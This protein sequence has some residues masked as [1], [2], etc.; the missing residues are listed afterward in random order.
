MPKQR[1][2]S[3]HRGSHTLWR[4][5]KILRAQVDLKVITNFRKED[6]KTGITDLDKLRV[7]H[8]LGAEVRYNNDVH[9]KIIVM[10]S[11]TAIISSAN[12]TR[13]G[14]RV[15]Y[16]AGVKIMDHESVK[17]AEEFFYGVWDNSQ[18]LT[19]EMIKNFE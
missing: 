5:S 18:L 10:D 8:D 19:E 15:N 17:M 7:L 1:F 16:E 2:W 3:V 13:N 4:S 12:L 6:V 9:A 14:L 11:K